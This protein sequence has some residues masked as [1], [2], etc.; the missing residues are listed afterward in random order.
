MKPDMGAQAPIPNPAAHDMGYPDDTQ[1]QTN[2]P[3]V[4]EDTVAGRQRM[5]TQDVVLRLAKIRG[6]LD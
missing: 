3:V 6:R 5:M 2:S 1:C 4:P